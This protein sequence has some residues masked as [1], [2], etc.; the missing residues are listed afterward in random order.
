MS[1]EG[2]R[3]RADRRSRTRERAGTSYRRYPPNPL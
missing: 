2:D 1:F 3:R